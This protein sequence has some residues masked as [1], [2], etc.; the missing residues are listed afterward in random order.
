MYILIRKSTE[1]FKNFE[2][3]FKKT[4]K[5]F[6]IHKK[7]NKGLHILLPTSPNLGQAR[8]RLSEKDNSE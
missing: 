6:S 4:K 8:G 2:K 1:R 7:D 3:I 5:K